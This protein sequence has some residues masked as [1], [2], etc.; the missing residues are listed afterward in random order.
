MLRLK[1]LDVEGFGTFAD[2]Q[3]LEFPDGPGV[4]VIYGENMRGKTWL[5]NAIRYAFFGKVLGRGARERR[6]HTVSN[7]DRAS[8]GKFGFSASLTFDYDGVEH[9]LV[10][11]CRPSV[12]VPMNDDDYTQTEM[13]RRGNATLGPQERAR[14]LQ[15]IFPKEV[16]RFFL[17]DGELLQEYEELLI[18]ESE[19]GH[20][21]SEAIERILGVPILKR[22]R[23]HLTKLSE[24]ADK[25]AAKE[26]SKLKVTEGLG[27]SLQLAIEQKEAHQQELARLQEQLQHLTDQRSE[28][29]QFLQSTQKYTSMLKERDDASARLDRAAK[30]EK[31]CRGELQRAMADAWRSL[32][33]EPIATARAAAQLAAERDLEA[34]L[35]SLRA[36]VVASGRCNTCNQD[37]PEGALALL[38]ATLPEEVLGDAVDPAAGAAPAMSRLAALSGFNPVDNAGEVRLLWLRLSA[39]ETE[40]VTQKDRISDLKADLAETDPEL[41]RRSQALWVDVVEKMMVVKR[42]IEDQSKQADDKDQNVQRLKKKLEESGTLDLRPGHL[43]ARILRDASEVFAAAVERYKAELRSRVEATA[44]KLFLSM[45]TEKRDFAGLTINESYGLTIRH[46]DGLAVEARSAGAEHVVALALIGAL[47]H[48]APLRGPIV[49]DSPFG[50]LDESHTGNV[51]RTLPEMADQVV[52]LVYESEVGKKRM[53]DL[54]GSRLL[55]EYELELVSSRRTNI[56]EVK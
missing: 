2:P 41:L 10:R 26:A 30:D 18:N 22:G 40:Q 50:R 33:R 32:L 9:E 54:L 7:R 55:R 20:R 51:V 5:L 44:S 8:E 17:F 12:K 31:A 4:T 27:V 53:R 24:D 16:S 14:A 6:L 1:R 36:R 21:I 47:Q 23:I 15:Q 13:L 46:Q 38:R 49:A 29:E 52:L 3:V 42:A 48:N 35:T 56:R 34:L 28:L 19:A 25:L 39:L 45:T 43:R 37:V 11:E